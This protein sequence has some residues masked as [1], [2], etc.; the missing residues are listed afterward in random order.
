MPA[1]GY[2]AAMGTLLGTNA[3]AIIG[4]S[5]VPYRRAEKW[6]WWVL[7]IIGVV[8]LLGW[9]FALQGGADTAAAIVGWT[10]LVL[11]LA[12]PAKAILGGKAGK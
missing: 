4:M 11:G 7:L 2:D 8:P 5:L 1:M 6:S 9:S 12:I 10:L 3:V